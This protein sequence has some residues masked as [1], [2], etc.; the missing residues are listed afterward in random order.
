MTVEK[1]NKIKVEYE[2]KY[3]DGTMFDSSKAHGQP[4]EFVVGSGMVVAG[5]DNAVVGM[6][7]GDEKEFTIE[8]A[9]AYGE[10][11]EELQQK[12][13]RDMLP[14]EQEP[15]VGMV[16]MVGTPDG[17]QA[18]VK[19]LSVDDE[20]ITIDLNHPLAGKKL[21]FKIKVISIEKGA[22]SETGESDESDSSKVQ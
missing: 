9:E 15:K 4:L 5:F 14:K 18:P 13:P 11:R 20:S 7:E 19:I 22:T 10:K 6:N 21:T 3:E 16:L 1:G 2:G 12:V 17:R 8:P